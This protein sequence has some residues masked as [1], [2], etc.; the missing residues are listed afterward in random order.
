MGPSENLSSGPSLGRPK[1]DDT[2]TRAPLS[3][4]Y[5][6]VSTEAR[7]RVSS[8]IVLPSR[9]TFRSQRIRTFL[10]IMVTV[11]AA[12]TRARRAA[13]TAGVRREAEAEETR[14]TCALPRRGIAAGA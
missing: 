14:A 13:F 10:P 11:G 7:M 2:A 3:T 9:G 8:V 4:R 5:L 6:M 1:W 12:L